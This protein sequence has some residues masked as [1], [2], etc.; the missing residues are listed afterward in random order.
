MSGVAGAR[1]FTVADTDWQTPET[2]HASFRGLCPHCG[3]GGLFSGIVRFAARCDRC[4][5]DFQQ[6]N[7]GDGP[8]AFLIM[9]V[10]AI[11]TGLA[12]AVQLSVEPPFWVH[13]LLWVPLTLALVLGLLRIAKAALLV[14]EYKNRAREGRLVE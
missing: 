9:I 7:V 14:L 5:L 8:A 2:A 11:I 12:I 4:G 3:A 13:I 10:G 6:F 1:R